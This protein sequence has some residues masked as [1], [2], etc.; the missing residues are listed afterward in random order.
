M[1][2][3]V[4]GYMFLINCTVHELAHYWVIF[5][6]AKCYN[7]PIGWDIAYIV[8]LWNTSNSLAVLNLILIISGCWRVQLLKWIWLVALG[9]I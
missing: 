3:F 2:E 1:R 9:V 7:H 4:A 6:L 8:K 5:D